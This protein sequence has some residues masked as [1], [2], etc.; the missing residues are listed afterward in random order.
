MAGGI[1]FVP[2]DCQLDEKF[3]YIEAEFGLIGFAVVV[4]LFQRIYGGHGYYCEWNDRVALLFAHKIGAGG[5]VVR[6]IVSAAIREGIFSKEMLE[7]FGV[8]T[9]RGIQK[10][11]SD[12]AKRRKEIF[13]KPEYVLLDYEQNS[14]DVDISGENVCN[15]DE[16]VCNPNTSKV[17]ESKASKDKGSEESSAA[18]P[19]APPPPKSPRELLAEKYGSAAVADY[20]QRYRNWQAKSGRTGGDMYAAIAKWMAQDGVTK[21][22]FAYRSSIDMDEVMRRNIE[23]YRKRK[24]ES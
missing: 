4:K 13:D 23:K 9:S 3:D 8:L 22:A 20:E 6:E 17:K 1:T 7:N 11:F 21:P 16:N 5:D 10:R 14:D 12:V 24:A 18:P 19:P 15:S 2:L